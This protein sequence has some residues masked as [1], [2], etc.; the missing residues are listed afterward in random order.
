MYYNS[1]ID[2]LCHY[3]SSTIQFSIESYMCIYNPV[4]LDEWQFYEQPDSMSCTIRVWKNFDGKCHRKCKSALHSL[5]EDGSIDA[6]E[7]YKNGTLHRKNAPA[8]IIYYADDV[9]ETES[10]YENG[11]HHRIDGPSVIEYY[12]DGSINSEEWYNQGD[13]HRVGA[14]A[15]VVCDEGGNIIDQDYF[16]NGE[17][18]DDAEPYGSL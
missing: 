13:R 6:E 5:K 1:A 2:V 8:R 18:I 9:L 14:P 7:W 15:I 3:L 12:Y 4:T 16:I 10:Y 11:L 17:S